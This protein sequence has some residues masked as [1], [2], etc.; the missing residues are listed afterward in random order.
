M[1]THAKPNR[2][3]IVGRVQGLL[4]YH[5]IE[6]APRRL[7]LH[8]NLWIESPASVPGIPFWAFRVSDILSQPT[9][10][11]VINALANAESAGCKPNINPL[12]KAAQRA[13]RRERLG[14]PPPV[15]GGSRSDY[16]VPFHIGVF[17]HPHRKWTQP[18]ITRDTLQGLTGTGPT[19]QTRI[20]KMM[21]LCRS[22]DDMVLDKLEPF[23]ADLRPGLVGKYRAYSQV[24]S[25]T[26]RILRHDL[27]TAT[28]PAEVLRG[29]ADRWPFLR[30]GNLGSTVA[31]GRGQS[32]KLHLDVHDD[33]VLPTVLMVVGNKNDY[34][35][36][37]DGDGDVILPTLGLSVPLFP[38]DALVF[39][40]SY[41]PHQVKLL[42]EAD[43]HKRIVT[44]LF[45]CA[46]TKADLEGRQ[47]TARG[48]GKKRAREETEDE[49]EVE[50]DY[51]SEQ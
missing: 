51:D 32:E 38:G 14:L 21:G 25:T 29:S 20:G 45:T 17:K 11:S 39:Y 15:D 27:D 37:S 42:P 48:K 7:P 6:T 8:G 26:D 50:G 49:E 30:F 24:R 3:N 10:T 12:K 41:L 16:E 31:I 47:T 23:L 46:R 18:W 33:E 1:V 4:R 19:R 22:I 43:R 5:E 36:H 35:D 13:R 40:S 28:L 44:T 2:V 9:M 34:W